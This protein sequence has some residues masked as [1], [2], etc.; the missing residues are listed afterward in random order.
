VADKVTEALKALGAFDESNAVITDFL[1]QQMV[2][3]GIHSCSNVIGATI[4]SRQ[5]IEGCMGRFARH[6]GGQ[7]EPW[8][9][10]EWALS[11]HTDVA[12]A[13]FHQR[14]FTFRRR[15]NAPRF[16]DAR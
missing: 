8:R 5:M 11:I 16:E 12:R 3:M 7:R 15:A 6:L 10:Y 2:R 13:P 9:G 14:L 4:G 1:A